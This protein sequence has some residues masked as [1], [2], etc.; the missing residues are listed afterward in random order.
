MAH[1]DL[2]QSLLKGLSI[3]DL[4]AQ[5]DRGLTLKEICELLEMRQP[6]AYNLLRTLAARN[7]VERTPPPV[8]Y[9]LGRTVI[10]L[11]DDLTRQELVNRAGDVLRSLYKDVVEVL[12]HEPG[13]DEE[14]AV[15][16]AKALGGEVR[17]LLRIRNDSPQVLSRPMSVMSPYRSTSSLI[18]QAYWSREER[19]GYRRAHPFDE[20]GASLWKSQG[21][22]NLYLHQ[23]RTQ[24]YAQPK[25]YPAGEYRLSVPVFDQGHILVGVLGV[26]AWM[27]TN[28]LV[29]FRVLRRMVDAAAELSGVPHPAKVQQ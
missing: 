21:K 7:Y 13:P 18:Y 26:G 20:L 28:P 29:S 22:L 4:L 1:S 23:I 9:G 5:S 12:P 25:I 6:T 24:A 27:R 15:S 3:L 2:V 14:V 10:R 17:L 19:D 11:A 16:F 8:R